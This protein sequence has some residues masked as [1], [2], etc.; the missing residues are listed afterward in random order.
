MDAAEYV[1]SVK[2]QLRAFDFVEED[3]YRNPG[4]IDSCFYRCTDGVVNTTE[5]VV[6]IVRLTEA[7]VESVKE[8]I[9]A[10]KSFFE[11]KEDGGLEATNRRWTYALLILDSAS[12]PVRTA[13]KRMVG[14]FEG[15]FILP[16][17]ATM[18]DEALVYERPG[19]LKK[20]GNH[21][22]VSENAQKYFKP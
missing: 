5:E 2:E 6:A 21:K 10:S 15:G 17:I 20:V 9:E 3:D 4:M 8:A 11:W 1:H 7:D 22:K 16:V 13:V 19:K 12:G 18:D 14:K